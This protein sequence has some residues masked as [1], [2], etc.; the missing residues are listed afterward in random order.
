MDRQ[1][2]VFL[3]IDVG[4]GSSRAALISD[5]GELLAIASTPFTTYRPHA[6]FFEQSTQEIWQ[7]VCTSVQAALNK[8]EMDAHRI[9]GIGF[10]ATCSLV[11][12]TSG[13][14]PES[15]RPV[16]ISPSSQFE[17]TNRDII[18][19][20]DHRAKEQAK[21]I[22]A[23]K[24]EIL[25]SVGGVMSLEMEL[26]K[27]LWLKDHMPEEKWRTVGR[28]FDLPDFLTFK[29]CG[30]TFP[31]RCSVVC[32]WCY[33]AKPESGE[34]DSSGSGSDDGSDDSICAGS[35]S[36][37]PA[38]FLMQIGLPELVENHCEK[39]CGPG[40]TDQTVHY[41][42][43]Y[44]GGLTEKAAQ[45]LGLVPGIAVGAAV[46]DAYAG[47]IGT[48]GASVAGK[49]PSIGEAQ[50]RIAII[51]GTSSCHLAMSK[52]KIF[53]PAYAQALDLAAAEQPALSIYTFLNRRVESLF[54]ASSLPHLAYLTKTLHLT[55]D[56]HGNRSPLADE[57]MRGLI[58]GLDLHGNTV[59]GLA[60]LYLATLQALALGT[61]QILEAL[62]RG[63]YEIDTICISGGQS[64]N[65]LF[66]QILADV[67]QKPIVHS[68]AGGEASV[69][70]GAAICGKVAYE[71]GERKQKEG[72]V[73]DMRTALWEAMTSLTRAERTVEP[74]RDQVLQQFYR[75]KYRVL[76]AMQHDQRK[77]ADIMARTD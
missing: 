63:G 68:H 30:E 6:D 46:I 57:T 62:Q 65:E 31:S 21:R 70:F 28:L 44:I 49:Q 24:H 72:K 11:V 9:K 17:D 56:H 12:S 75:N 14:T 51:C 37:W 33:S 3:G 74:T 27:T 1:G 67:T 38:D 25:K 55:P 32:K 22:T 45:E 36:G 35:A 10:D 54:K 29:A 76:E 4:S 5:S 53:V 48:L 69:V 18:M 59:D 8:A 19:W 42:G 58:T 41:A 50:T 71:T 26:P 77:Y 66:V 52:K 73:D 40:N 13:S 47:A 39:L 23:T 15:A 61:Q 43:E 2:N 64:L 16:S 34:N 60:L 7:S 20:C